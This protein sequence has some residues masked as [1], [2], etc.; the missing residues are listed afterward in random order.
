MGAIWMYKRMNEGTGI[1]C[2]MDMPEIN[3]ARSMLQEMKSFTS[4]QFSE[5]I[6]CRL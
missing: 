2:A 1:R 4:V 6:F 3:F 5:Q